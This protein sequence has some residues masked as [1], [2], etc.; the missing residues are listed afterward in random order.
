M[1]ASD[2]GCGTQQDGKQACANATN[3]STK[4]FQ[5]L[6]YPKTPRLTSRETAKRI[7]EGF[8]SHRLSSISPTAYDHA[9][10]KAIRR[11]N[12]QSHHP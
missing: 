6:K 4:K 1:T 5:Y 10:V 11:R 7:R 8:A 3:E 9:L 12:R 2:D